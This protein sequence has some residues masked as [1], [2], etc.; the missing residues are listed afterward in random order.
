MKTKCVIS[1]MQYCLVIKTE[2]LANYSWKWQLATS[3]ITRLSASYQHP[4]NTALTLIVNTFTL[5]TVSSYDLLDIQYATSSCFVRE[6]H[7][8]S[9]II[10]IVCHQ[11][12]N[13]Y[14]IVDQE[15]QRFIY[16]I[17][18]RHTILSYELFNRSHL[19]IILKLP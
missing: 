10:I 16:I 1:R 15:M 13:Y 9:C 8:N 4:D 12:V 17:K 14:S 5:S 19:A 6:S 3:A 18:A 7:F 11:T 2:Q